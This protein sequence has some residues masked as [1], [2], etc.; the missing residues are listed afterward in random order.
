MKQTNFQKKL[1]ANLEMTFFL[2]E[3]TNAGIIS[4]EN[5]KLTN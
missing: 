5:F 3:N 4:R 1:T 2:V